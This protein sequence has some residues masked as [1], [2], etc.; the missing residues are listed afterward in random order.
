M[1]LASIDFDPIFGKKVLFLP[2]FWSR[3]CIFKTHFRP[4]IYT[5]LVKDDHELFFEPKIYSFSSRNYYFIYF[6]YQKWPDLNIFRYFPSIWWCCVRPCVPSILDIAKWNHKM[7]SK[8]W[9][10]RLIL[11]CCWISNCPMCQVCC[12]SPSRTRPS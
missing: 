10:P 9:S 7:V 11:S 1:N 12:R 3:K 5:F 4:K 8:C 2:W 6:F